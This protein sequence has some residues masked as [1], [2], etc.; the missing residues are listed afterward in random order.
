MGASEAI[1]APETWT[2]PPLS[3]DLEFW[4]ASSERAQ[5]VPCLGERQEWLKLEKQTSI[6]RV[7]G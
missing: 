6:F 3:L 4:S 2:T 5:N 1:E 7:S